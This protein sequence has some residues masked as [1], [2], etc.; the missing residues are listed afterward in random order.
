MKNKKTAKKLFYTIIFGLGFILIYVFF[1][2]SLFSRNLAAS[3]QEMNKVKVGIDSDLIISQSEMFFS[4]DPQFLTESNQIAI[5]LF[6]EPLVRFDEFLD[7]E[8]ALAQSWYL[9]DST[10]FVIELRN[11]VFHDGKVLS[12]E[13]VEA[14]LRRAKNNPHSHLQKTFAGV[15]LIQLKPK[16]CEFVL[17]SRDTD[18]LQK[19]TQLFIVPSSVVQSLS[20]TV[21]PIGTG[22]YRLIFRDNSRL[23]FEA[24][25][26]YYFLNSHVP[27]RITLLGGEDQIGLA[28]I[29]IDINESSIPK[30][31]REGYEILFA[32]TF[33]LDKRRFYA[34]YKGINIFHPR[35]DGLIIFDF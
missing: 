32:P 33:Q 9:S 7:I 30:F 25:S 18:F 20:K 11:A 15:E 22:R 28:D 17:P 27:Y 26:D 1:N 2:Y 29:I 34:V 31:E 24:F 13:D 14:S 12:C 23:V 4:L 16:I 35:M 21:S 3:V 5:A 10:H 6:L 8:P 19:L